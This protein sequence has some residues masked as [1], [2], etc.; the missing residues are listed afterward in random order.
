MFSCTVNSIAEAIDESIKH[1][2][3]HGE[4][5]SPRGIGPIEV[6]PAVIVLTEPRNRVVSIEGRNANPA[7]AAA[8][9]MWILSG[10][11]EPW[12]FNFNRSLLK[13]A[14]DG[15]LRGAYGPRLRRWSGTVDQIAWVIQTLRDDPDSRRAVI[16]IYDP[17][18]VEAHHNDIPCTISFRFFIRN[19]ALTMHTLM[20]AND[21][22][23]GMPYDMFC[24]TAIQEI[25]AYNLRVPMSN[26]VHMVDSLHLYDSDF[27]RAK[28]IVLPAKNKQDVHC[29]HKPIGIELEKM[30]GAL[31]DAI[32]K[33]DGTGAFA[34]YGAM[35][36]LYEE[37]KAGRKI[38]PALFEALSPAFRN[39]FEIWIERR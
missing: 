27:E 22:W 7:F 24:F 23:L 14:N 20:R 4:R 5:V 35:L 11:D 25:V 33:R 10:S 9:T 37:A 3:Q 19:G 18:T 17:G 34:E 39:A 16:Q 2:M 32:H 29:Q 21:V 8:E 26:Y 28:K 1:L 31:R 15:I 30:D 38:N 12:I 13:F 36:A 6:R